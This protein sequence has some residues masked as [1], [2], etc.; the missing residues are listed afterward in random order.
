MATRRLR[1]PR[2]VGRIGR[3]AYPH[4]IE[5]A[6]E[7]RLAGAVE[8]AWTVLEE[9]L[10]PAYERESGRRS[11]ADDHP[12]QG[13]IAGVRFAW[14]R[15]FERVSDEITEGPDA[16]EFHKGAIVE[17][18][19]SVVPVNP[20][21]SEPWLGP[22][23]DAW[24]A[25]NVGL[26]RSVPDRALDQVSDLVAESWSKGRSTADL[27]RH[28]RDRLGV[29]RRRAELIARDQIGKLN[30]ELTAMRQSALGIE[31]YIW[32]TS[33]DERVRQMHADRHGDRF[34]WDAPPDDG[35]PGIPIQCR[36]TAEPDVDAALDALEQDYVGSDVHAERMHTRMEET[37]RALGSFAESE[38]QIAPILA[39]MPSVA[40][41]QDALAAGQAI[42]AS[43]ASAPKVT[44]RPRKT[45]RTSSRTPRRSP[46]AAQPA[47]GSTS[48]SPTGPPPAFATIDEAADWIDRRFG[49]KYTPDL[50]DRFGPKYRKATSK[51]AELEILQ[52][53][54]EELDRL[55]GMGLDLNRIRGLRVTV[56]R[57]PEGVGG[58]ASVGNRIPNGEKG[59]L[60]L[61]QSTRRETPAAPGVKAF[62]VTQREL[63]VENTMRVQ[64]ASVFRHELGH[65]LTDGPAV[66]IF[67][68]HLSRDPFWRITRYGGTRWEEGFAESFCEYTRAD[69]VGGGEG[70]RSLPSEVERAMRAAMTG[71]R[72]TTDERD[73]RPSEGELLE[74]VYAPPEGQRYI[75]EEQD[76]GL[77]PIPVGTEPGEED[78]PPASE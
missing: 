71:K 44:R 27:Q 49:V 3:A 30:G 76:N 46:R 10:L 61:N 40:A 68:T 5:R 54:A 26:I 74:W 56:A 34:S 9:E 37:V 20:I 67:R 31:S 23:M 8:R 58:S 66:D 75:W 38:S 51:R 60:L 16:A 4:A 69:Y 18:L 59:V 55:E 42:A 1:N 29:T 7:R 52:I 28:L 22:V 11:D 63:A 2:R 14:G 48:A 50:A 78:V 72:P 53:M 57:M 77:T 36:C 6:Y 70:L 13:T 45:P 41:I 73:R 65:I 33:R 24:R 25:S 43:T 17:Q 39:A 19:G 12:F 47:R 32:Q 64:R 62:S 21:R 35:H 15:W